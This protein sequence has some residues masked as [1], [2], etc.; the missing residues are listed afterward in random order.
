MGILVLPPDVNS[1]DWNF[2]PDGDAIRFGLG[3][4]KNLG[5][6]AVEAIQ[7]ARAEVGR[8]RSIFQFCEKVDHA[9]INRRMIESL[10]RAGALDSLEGTRS[11]LMAAVE[12]AMEHGQRVWRDRLS[13]QGGLF[14]AMA[15]EAEEVP[16]QLPRVPDWSAAE[17]LTGEKEMLG[18][19]VTGH[20]LD[21]HAQK[22]ADLATHDSES[23]EGL[24]RGAEVAVCGILTGITRKR[25]KE[26]RLWATMQLED[27]RGNVEMLLF[28]SQYEKNLQFLVEDKAVLVRGTVLPEENAPPRLSAQDIVPLDLARVAFPSLISIRVVIGR[29]NGADV[30]ERLRELFQRKKGDTEVRLRL[31]KLRDFSMI[32][33]VSE[34]VRPDKEFRAEVERICGPEAYEVLA[35]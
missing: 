1:S 33:D 2:T 5:S 32:L 10:I 9:A 16:E 29:A 31:E 3:P 21:D 23:L 8:L 35:T 27:R 12:T 11:Q 20:P 18:F 22:V 6:N 19:Y 7:R 15:E 30:A 25:N 28:A 4:V 13:G 34:K 14:A 26:G 17:K 24:S